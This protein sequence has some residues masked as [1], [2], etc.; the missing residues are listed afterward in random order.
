VR[1]TDEDMCW[2]QL[3]AG[4]MCARADG[5]DAK[6]V[7]AGVFAQMIDLR[8]KTAF[9]ARAGA[10][11]EVGRVEVDGANHIPLMTDFPQPNLIQPVGVAKLD[12]GKLVFADGASLYA[13]APDAPSDRASA[14]QMWSGSVGD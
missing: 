1:A 9:F 10:P 2:G 7:N 13:I 3:E 6:L 12:G 14:I 8:G 5:G 4:V 11:L